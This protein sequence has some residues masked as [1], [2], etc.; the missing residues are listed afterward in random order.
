GSKSWAGGGGGARGVWGWGV[1]WARAVAVAAAQNPPPAG[2]VTLKGQVVIPA[3]APIPQRQPLMVGGPNGPACLKNGPILDETVIVNPKNRGVKNED[4]WLHPNNAM[5]PN[6]AF[7]P[8]GTHPAA[9]NRTTAEVGIYQ[10]AP[11]SR[12]R[13]PDAR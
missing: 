6:A 1:G 8:N 2:W 3:N 9:A 12:G 5:N 10:A 7:A 11:M 4:V 13:R